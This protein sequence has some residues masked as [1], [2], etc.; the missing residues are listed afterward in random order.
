MDHHCPWVNNCVGYYNQKFFLQFLI[1]VFLGSFHAVVLIAWQ[2]YLCMYDNCVMFIDMST[3]ILC[4]VGIFLA[5]LFCI[6]VC[7]MFYDQ[8]TCI[9]EMRS[10]IDKLQIKRAISLGK[11]YVEDPKPSK[12]WWENICEVMTGKMHLGFDIYW[13]IP[14]DLEYPLC[15]EAEYF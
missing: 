8:I 10:T 5:V 15:V 2:G 11:K 9:V 6:F 1:Y 12:T 7:V 4:V 13:L 14:T 3:V